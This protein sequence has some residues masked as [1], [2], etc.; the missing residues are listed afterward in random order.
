MYQALF[1]VALPV[2]PPSQSLF[3]LFGL[4]SKLG[5]KCSVLV[6]VSVAACCLGFD[7]PPSNYLT[8]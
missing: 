1:N 6:Y 5:L 3:D 4:W 7:L 8:L 2:I